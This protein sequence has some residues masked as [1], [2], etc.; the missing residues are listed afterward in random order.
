[1]LASGTEIYCRGQEY[2]CDATSKNFEHRVHGY[3]VVTETGR[4]LSMHRGQPAS[5]NKHCTMYW[6]KANVRSASRTNG[7]QE[8]T[9]SNVL[10]DLANER[11]T[12]RTLLMTGIKFEKG[13]IDYSEL[14]R[15][16]CYIDNVRLLKGKCTQKTYLWR[17]WVRLFFKG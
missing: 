14:K 2:H 9:Y 15:A 4:L 10:G 16:V 11:S 6:C 8:R 17:M 13:R 3:K 12:W 5:R 7:T 1:M